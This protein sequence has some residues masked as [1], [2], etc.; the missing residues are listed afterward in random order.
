[1]AKTKRALVGGFVLP[2]RKQI[3]LELLPP[4][5]TASQTIEALIERYIAEQQQQ[6][7]S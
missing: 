7:A 4:G 1:M 6:R 2:E 3:F 5:R